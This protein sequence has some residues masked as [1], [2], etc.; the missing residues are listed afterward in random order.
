ME[1]QPGLSTEH[2]KA[3]KNTKYFILVPEITI[4]LV[5]PVVWTLEF[6]RIF[7]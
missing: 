1:K 3:L 6:L 5:W 7:W 2:W 4:Q